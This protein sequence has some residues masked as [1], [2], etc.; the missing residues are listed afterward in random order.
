M[1][2]ASQGKRAKT[3]LTLGL[4]GLHQLFSDQAIFS[5]CDVPR[6]QPHPDLFLHAAGQMQTPAEACVVVEDTT[7]GIPCRSYCQHDGDRARQRLRGRANEPAGR[8]HDRIATG[9]PAAAAEPELADRSCLLTKHQA[10]SWS[11]AT[12]AIASPNLRASS[13]AAAAGS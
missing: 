3:E 12:A 8:H 6:G 10:P 4:A 7:I 11:S 5:A 2:V 1:C 13:E 9:S